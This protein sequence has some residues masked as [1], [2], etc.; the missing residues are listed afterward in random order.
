[1]FIK[2][3][4]DYS[5]NSDAILYVEWNKVIDLVEQE[6]G[7]KI[8]WRQTH[9]H[10]KGSQTVLILSDNTSLNYDTNV[11]QLKKALGVTA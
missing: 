10:F 2:L 11:R 6:T 8:Q 9:I 1:M 4:E 3:A 7:K 5:V